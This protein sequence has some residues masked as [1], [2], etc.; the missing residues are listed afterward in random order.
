[1]AVITLTIDQSM[2]DA[3]N[4]AYGKPVSLESAIKQ[5]LT[6]LLLDRITPVVVEKATTQLRTALSTMQVEVKA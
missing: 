5:Q 3:L 1:M 2:V 6:N 4:E